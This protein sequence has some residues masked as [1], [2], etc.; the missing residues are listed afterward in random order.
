MS[1]KINVII[2]IACIA[3]IIATA[4]IYGG[5]NTE[6]FWSDFLLSIILKHPCAAVVAVTEA[7]HL[8]FRSWKT[9]LV[10]LA[11]SA[12]ILSGTGAMTLLMTLQATPEVRKELFVTLAINVAITAV[13]Y[14]KMRKGKVNDNG[15][16]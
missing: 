10:G 11:I 16:T 4:L 5:T 6:P 12:F 14:I 2:I 8:K 9:E 15:I 1:R 3:L 7:V 13:L